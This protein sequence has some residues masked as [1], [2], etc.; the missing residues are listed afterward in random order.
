MAKIGNINQTRKEPIPKK[1][2]IGSSKNTRF[3]SK[4]DKRIKKEYRGQGH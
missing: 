2:S 3:S 1:T 4:N